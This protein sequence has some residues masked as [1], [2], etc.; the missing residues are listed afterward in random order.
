M[1]GLRCYALRHAADRREGEDDGFQPDGWP[2]ENKTI[3][4]HD[5]FNVYREGFHAGN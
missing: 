2:P 4:V 3:N 5:L 1:G